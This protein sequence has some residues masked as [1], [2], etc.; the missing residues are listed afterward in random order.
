EVAALKADCERLREVARAA[1]VSEARAAAEKEAA[2]G[3][4]AAAAEKCAAAEAKVE[5][6]SAEIMRL[7][8]EHSAAQAR[9]A[10]AQAEVRAKDDELTRQKT[11]F[12]EQTQHLKAL[13]NNTAN[14]LLQ[15]RAAQFGTENKQQIAA[16]LQPFQQQLL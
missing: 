6:L 8:G 16:L 9:L 4:A 10:S 5:G 14:Q 13:F 1:E 15:E 7:Q 2:S 11:W 3:K 12:D